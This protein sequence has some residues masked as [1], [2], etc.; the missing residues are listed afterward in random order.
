MS[1]CNADAI[2]PF[3]PSAGRGPNPRWVREPPIR[4]F[5]TSGFA[6]GNALRNLPLRRPD[7]APPGPRSHPGRWIAERSLSETADRRPQ[8]PGLPAATPWSPS[9]HPTVGIPNRATARGRCCRKPTFS[10]SVINENNITDPLLHRQVG[11][12]ERVSGLGL[13][14]RDA[15]DQPAG[16]PENVNHAFHGGRGNRIHRR[17]TATDFTG[18]AA[19]ERRD[20]DRLRCRQGQAETWR[21]AGLLTVD[22]EKFHGLHRP[23]C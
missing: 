11:I 4:P 6:R 19:R 2:S 16:N 23:F 9:T 10:G 15:K 3:G 1:F 12:L 20:Y 8:L 18:F 22:A 5:D 14:G 17:S 21:D 13:K 7:A